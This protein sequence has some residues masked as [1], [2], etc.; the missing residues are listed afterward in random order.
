MSKNLFYISLLIVFVSL[1]SCQKNIDLQ[2]FD[3][4][5]WKKD[6]KGCQNRRLALWDEF[7]KKIKPQ[8]KGL[9]EKEVYALLGK[10]D[11]QE[12][13]KRN[14]KFYYYFLEAGNHCDTTNTKIARRMQIRFDA[15]NNV[16]EI[17]TAYN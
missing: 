15:I 17:V 7:D 11:R 6:S 10:A 13:S 2:G 3:M 4:E 12:L 5:T 1:T 16:S 8:L 14:Q 9:S